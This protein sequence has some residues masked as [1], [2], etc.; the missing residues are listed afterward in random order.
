MG[1]RAR[2]GRAPPAGSRGM[3]SVA[4]HQA[5]QRA[6]L[7]P[8]PPLPHKTNPGWTQGGVGTTALS[9][10]ERWTWSVGEL[11]AHTD[12]HNPWIIEHRL[13]RHGQRCQMPR[14]LRLHR[15]MEDRPCRSRRLT[16]HRAR[17]I[18]S[19][20]SRPRTTTIGHGQAVNM[21]ILGHS[22]VATL[23]VGA[24][25][26]AISAGARPAPGP[27]AGREHDDRARR[28]PAPR[29]MPSMRTGDPS[30]A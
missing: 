19:R 17:A 23:S 2:T 18:C 10:L 29:S 22:L 27:S 3:G 21:L 16:R 26:P 9:R 8:V 24:I 12:A 7:A 13:P 15:H 5:R 20:R 25:A 1:G 30:S 11:K 6:A 28:D 4:T 14:K